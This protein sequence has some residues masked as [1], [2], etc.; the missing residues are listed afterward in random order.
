MQGKLFPTPPFDF[1]KSLHF[2]GMFAPTE[3]EQSIS[4]ASFTKAI[5]LGNQTLA[6]RL[7]AEGTIEEPI[8]SYT[9]F[10]H[11][12]INNKIESALLD[13]I[14]FFFWRLKIKNFE[15]VHN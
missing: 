1:S 14:K 15:S 12:K 5:Y 4:D 11:D 10:A 9:L 7:E 2:A 13:R 3:G 6:F 8:L